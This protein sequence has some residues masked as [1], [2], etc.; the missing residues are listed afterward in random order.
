MAQVNSENSTAM[1]ASGAGAL[2]FP[3]DITPEGRLRKDARDEVERLIQFLDK[4]D[5]Y[6]SRELE[7]D[8]DLEAVGDEEPSLGSFDRMTDQSKAWG[9]HRLWDPPEVDAE[10]DDAETEPSLGSL[11]QHNNQEQW[12]AGDPRDL[13]L[14]GAES[15]IGDLDGLLEQIGT[16]DWTAGRGGMV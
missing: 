2:Y 1:P 5:D 7:D 9:Q 4:T 12:A 14:D 10:Q 11:D 8:D 15:G 6:V 13:E 3:T 16:N